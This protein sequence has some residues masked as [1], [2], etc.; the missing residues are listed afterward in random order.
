MPELEEVRVARGTQI[1]ALVT[2]GV[3]ALAVVLAGFVTWWRV[4]GPTF[5]VQ[6][7]IATEATPMLAASQLDASTFSAV[8]LILRGDFA[9]ARWLQ[10]GS[11]LL[12]YS[13]IFVGLGLLAWALWRLRVAHSFGRVVTRTLGLFGGWVIIATTLSSALSVLATRTAVSQLGLSDTQVAGSDLLLPPEFALTPPIQ[14]ALVVGALLIVLAVFVHRG[15]QMQEEL[16]E[17]I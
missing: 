15:A 5:E 16:D 6:V 7:G 8:E 17:V 2:A 13:V 3:A 12:G 11:L 10:A 9:T 14:V 4:S 1:V